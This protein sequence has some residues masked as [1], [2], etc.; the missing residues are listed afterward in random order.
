MMRPSRRNWSTP[1]SPKRCPEWSFWR[2]DPSNFAGFVREWIPA[3]PV[4][5][6]L[7]RVLSLI[8]HRL[9]KPDSATL[10]QAWGTKHGEVD[11]LCLHPHGDR[12]PTDLGNSAGGCCIMALQ[13]GEKG[14]A[15]GRPNKKRADPQIWGSARKEA[16]W[17]ITDYIPS[18]CC[19]IES[20]RR[21]WRV[22]PFFVV[23]PST[24]PW[25]EVERREAGTPLSW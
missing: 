23:T 8:Q 18:S 20:A 1:A 4:L 15:A 2:P 22:P 16:Q 9:R 11:G 12:R 21:Y 19:G 24:C 13:P 3:R 7:S 17:P 10:I 25:P 6:M 14:G 5:P